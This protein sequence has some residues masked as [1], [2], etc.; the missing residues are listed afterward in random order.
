M[1]HV[2]NMM[3]VHLG[4]TDEESVLL[5]AEWRSGCIW[6]QRLWSR[7][8]C[9]INLC[10]ELCVLVVTGQVH[11]QHLVW[12]RIL[13]L[14]MQVLHCHVLHCCSHARLGEFSACPTLPQTALCRSP[15]RCKA[16]RRLTMGCTDVMHAPQHDALCCDVT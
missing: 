3:Q 14:P 16:R 6:A 8:R 4:S 10:M 12:V 13:Y 15:L 1:Y 2:H 5:L 11:L 9:G 7:P